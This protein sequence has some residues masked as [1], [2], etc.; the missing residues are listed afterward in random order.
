VILIVGCCLL[1]VADTL[2]TDPA[3]VRGVTSPDGKYKAVVTER[4]SWQSFAPVMPGHGSDAPGYVTIYRLSD[5]QSCGRA[6]VE[7]MW[8]A[9]VE[10]GEDT[11]R[12]EN[13]ASWDL[14]DCSV[15]AMDW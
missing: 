7:F 15:S 12:V 8:M 13:V 5:G 9:D 6:P 11:A 10:W 2:W 14:V 1:A 4:F 3:D